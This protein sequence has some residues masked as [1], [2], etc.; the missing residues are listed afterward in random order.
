MK[1]ARVFVSGFVQGV[2]FRRFLRHNANKIGIKGWAKNLQ[3]NRVEAIFQGPE[4]KVNEMIKIC[5]KGAFLSEVKDVAV[6]IIESNEK[7]NSFEIR[8]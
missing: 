4:D 3:D 8:Y 6:E 1:T 5:K 7:F 2:G